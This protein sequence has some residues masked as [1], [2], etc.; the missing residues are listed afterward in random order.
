MTR[1][2]EIV[3]NKIFA[4]AYD[5]YKKKKKNFKFAQSIFI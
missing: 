4:Q 1:Y 5:C 2:I 3:R